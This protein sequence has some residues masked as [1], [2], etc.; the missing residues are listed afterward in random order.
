MF[1]NGLRDRGSVLGRIIPKTL[2]MVLDAFLLN[3]KPFKVRVK[4]K[5]EQF[6]EMSG[7]IYNN[8]V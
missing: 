2:K 5:V 6:K 7:A 4:G 3:T 8:S 1:A